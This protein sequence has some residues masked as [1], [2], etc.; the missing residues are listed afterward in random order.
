MAD[1]QPSITS[2]I[3]KTRLTAPSYRQ[4]GVGLFFILGSIIL[5]I[6]LGLLA[7]IYFYR[8]SLQKDIDGLSASLERARAAFEPQL[9]NELSGLNNS[10]DAS[11]ELFSRHQAVS[12]IFKII[13]SS[14]LPNVA[15]SNFNYKI[16]SG[17]NSVVSMT[18]EATSYT[19]VAIQA[20]I[21]RDNDA[22]DQVSF[23]NLSLK[24]AGR[25]S[26]NLQLVFK[27]SSLIYKIQ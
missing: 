15:F 14:T 8:Q 27:S 13:E 3:P 18:G 9:I 10:I 11:T 4:K 7:A 6:S 22:I 2:F 23:S 20:K 16:S 5:V 19:Q 12:N 26:F 24:E 25:V 21:F 1:S 17:G